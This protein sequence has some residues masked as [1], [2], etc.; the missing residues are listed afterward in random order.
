VH[1]GVHIDTKQ[2]QTMPYDHP[3]PP[4]YYNIIK[5]TEFMMKVK[6]C[7]DITQVSDNF[8]TEEDWI[9]LKKT[10]NQRHHWN[11]AI[12]FNEPI[13]KVLKQFADNIKPGRMSTTVAPFEMAELL[14]L[15]EKYGWYVIGHN[16]PDGFEMHGTSKIINTK[17]WKKKSSKQTK[18]AD[19]LLERD[20]NSLLKACEDAIYNRHNYWITMKLDRH[21]SNTV[22][23]IKLCKHLVNWQNVTKQLKRTVYYRGKLD[24]PWIK[25]LWNDPSLANTLK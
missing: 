23:A 17:L 21:N 22:A 4:K 7:D 25:Q 9:T 3:S 5:R 24:L 1:R 2:E 19:K 16:L 14:N 8:L 10:N 15:K 13:R 12:I 11:N 18:R 6:Q 20:V